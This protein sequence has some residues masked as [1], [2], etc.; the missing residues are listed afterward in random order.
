MSTAFVFVLLATPF[1]P[2]TLC[3]WLYAWDCQLSFVLSALLWY[4][5][6]WNDSFQNHF[7]L[8]TGNLLVCV[9]NHLL[10]A[11]VYVSLNVTVSIHNPA[12]QT[13][14]LAYARLSQSYNRHSSIKIVITIT[15]AL[16]VSQLVMLWVLDILVVCF[17]SV[18]P[19]I[20]ILS[21]RRRGIRRGGTC[22]GGHARREG[23]SSI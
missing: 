4:S 21:V 1:L 17:V 10:S 23:R 20:G 7:L 12:L 8:E 15:S 11:I 14:S 22:R 9:G 16:R 13:G 19:C 5:R 6:V 2:D 18:E 3:L